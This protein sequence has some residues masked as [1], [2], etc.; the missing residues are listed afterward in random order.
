MVL[1]KK[2]TPINEPT[3]LKCIVCGV[4]GREKNQ[5]RRKSK[6]KGGGQRT[7][8]QLSCKQKASGATKAEVN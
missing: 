4:E 2:Q 8:W 7:Q 6:S 1:K 3:T 5:D